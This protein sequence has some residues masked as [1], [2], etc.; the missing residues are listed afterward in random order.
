MCGIILSCV[1]S[2]LVFFKTTKKWLQRRRIKAIIKNNLTFTPF[3]TLR[4]PKRAHLPLSLHPTTQVTSWPLGLA[5]CHSNK[6][7]SIQ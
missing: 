7:I 1:I 3:Y 2:Y 4:H 5:C 6:V